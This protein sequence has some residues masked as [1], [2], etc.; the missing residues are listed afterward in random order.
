MIKV[1]V[2]IC[3]VIS[4]QRILSA[5]SES[6]ICVSAN[7]IPSFAGCGR[8]DELDKKEKKP[9]TFGS[10]RQLACVVTAWLHSLHFF[11]PRDKAPKWNSEQ[12]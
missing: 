12:E 6:V 11:S 8:L 1:E 9:E 10:F 4:I 7:N 5:P 2:K 3:N